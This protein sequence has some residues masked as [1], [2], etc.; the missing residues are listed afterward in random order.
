MNITSIFD[1]SFRPYGTVLEGYDFTEFLS[2][3][4]KTAIPENGVAYMPSVPELEADPVFMQLQH[5]FY[6]G[7]PI[8]IGC[9]NGRNHA[10]N[11][12]E[13]HR[14]SEINIG[15]G[16]F[17]LLLATMTDIHNDQV[18]TQH[19]KTFHVPR[20]TAVQLFATTLHY[21]PCSN[22]PAQEFQVAVVLP[23]GTNTGIPALTP[24]CQEDRLLWAKNKWLMAHPDA[25]EAKAGAFVGLTGKNITLA[26]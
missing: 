1:P 19:V 13:Y 4:E 20:G 26:W 2:A 24:C 21:A 17:I 6:G 14:D 7:M 23:K 9:C 3:L 18:D 10:L 16:D 5:H 25:P 12:L 8:Q 22:G 15:T 11:C